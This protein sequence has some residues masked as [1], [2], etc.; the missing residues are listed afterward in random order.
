MS[1]LNRKDELFK[2][3]ESY[4]VTTGFDPIDSRIY[5]LALSKGKITS[6]DVSDE[7]TDIRQSTAVA[8]LKNLAKKGYLD[9]IQIETAS[10][11]PYAMEFRA[12]NPRNALKEKLQKAKELPQL[13]ERYDEHWEA[14]GENPTQDTEIWL[15]KSES[16]GARIG[17]SIFEGAKQEIKIYS[18]DCSWCKYPDINESLENT[19]SNGVTVTIIA[20]NPKII[21]KSV[22]KMN[23]V[24]KFTE[25]NYGPPFCIV[26]IDWLILPIQNGT[27]SK[28]FSMIRTNDK[29]L[30]ENFSG[31]FKNALNHSSDWGKNNV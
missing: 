23:A 3:I 4:L 9:M 22:K 30:I 24:L 29:Y 1:G 21:Q 31:L 11:K 20:N 7:F 16:V 13:L 25:E 6:S 10:R 5:V 27:L 28:K 2:G 17:A 12:V 14:L 26:D 18:H 15:S 19:C 8:R